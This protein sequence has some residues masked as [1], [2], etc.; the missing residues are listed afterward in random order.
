MYTQHCGRVLNDA[1]FYFWIQEADVLFLSTFQARQGMSSRAAGY[2]KRNQ[3]G[4]WE[5]A[6][7]HS[8]PTSLLNCLI[9]FPGHGQHLV[10]LF[11]ASNGKGTKGDGALD[12]GKGPTR[13]LLL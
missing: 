4:G 10:L 11:L 1:G 13:T 9:K 7:S 6:H 2:T 5:S 12:V 8:P 3:A